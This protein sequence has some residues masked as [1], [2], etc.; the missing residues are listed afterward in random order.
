MEVQMFNFLGK[1]QKEKI[2]KKEK[3]AN[4][5]YKL[6]ENKLKNLMDKIDS[7]EEIIIVRKAN[8]A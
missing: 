8:H 4:F 7:L 3:Q 1:K 6:A 2:E 5:Q